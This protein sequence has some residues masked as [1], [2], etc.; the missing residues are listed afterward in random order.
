M[1]P[2]PSCRLLVLFFLITA[3]V[4]PSIPAYSAKQPTPSVE[5]TLENAPPEKVDSILARLSDEQVRNLLIAELS[6]D[7]PTQKSGDAQGGGLFKV[8][9][10]WLHMF[11]VQ[12]E[13][14]VE[15]RVRRIV[16]HVGKVPGD[17]AGVFSQFGNGHGM[18]SAWWNVVILIVILAAALMVEL[19]CKTLT[20]NF[21]R[22]FLCQAVP[23][24]TGYMRLWAG[25]IREIPL[26]VH[27]VIFVGASLFIFMLT[28]LH[29]IQSVHYLFMAILF[30]I[31][32]IR[33]GVILSSLFCSP[34]LAELRFLPFG[35]STAYS[36]HRIILFFFTYIGIGMSFIVLVSE[37]GIPRES[38]VLIVICLGSVLL[39][40]TAVILIRNRQPITEYILSAETVDKGSNWVMRQFASLW[41]IPALLYLFIVW[42]VF[43][44]QQI[45]G[46]R[47]D[48]GAFLFSLLVV[49]IFLLLDRIAQLVVQMAVGTLKVYPGSEEKSRDENDGDE[50]TPDKK[51]RL[52]VVRVGRVVRLTILLALVGW[53]MTLWGYQ[54]PYMATVTR[55]VL[56]S[57]VTLSL[58]LLFWRVLS[59]YIENK[60]RQDE[61]V[62]E[63][64]DQH[65]EEWGAAA[66]RGRSYTLLPMIR[67]FIGS[68]LVVMVTLIILS[69]MG[70][71]IGPLL[72]GAGVVGL[73]IGFG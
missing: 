57:L 8:V 47:Q 36:L 22:E 59:A 46:I 20:A 50:L 60:I 52:L 35:D 27:L 70:I 30:V 1:Q 55:I 42:I 18:G 26:V 56:S 28:P 68:V 69:T 37:L 33:I 58:A 3:F 2:I 41:H 31:L 5:K 6:R 54:I 23:D 62:K 71:E 19:L 39:L 65:D 16:D 13:Q 53:V 9:N 61:P 15:S 45:L 21:R 34:N 14:E 12:N 51:E 67:K 48:K 64:D 24:L 38:L 63:Q 40:M 43:V 7:K 29:D 49:P 10:V 66:Q 11:D 17:L 4:F 32:F 73:A 25:I 72:A 44:F